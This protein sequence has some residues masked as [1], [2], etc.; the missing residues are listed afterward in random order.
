VEGR[1]GDVESHSRRLT[2]LE[3]LTKS[4]QLVIHAMTV[5]NMRRKA[6]YDK[7][8]IH[9]KEL[10][11]GDLALLHNSKKH[12]EKL[13]LTRNGPYVVHHINENE[14]ILLKTLEC[15]LFPGYINGC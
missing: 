1:L 15:E 2:T 6:W 11:D 7:T 10:H 13:K 8:I 12:K 4:R 5:E 9:N 3:K 14:A